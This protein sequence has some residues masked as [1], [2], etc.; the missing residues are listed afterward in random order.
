LEASL[1]STN[2][3]LSDVEYWDSVAKKLL[4]DRGRFRDNWRKRRNELSRILNRY[5][6]EN[7]IILEIGTGMGVIGAMLLLCFA[8]HSY[9]G[10]EMSSVFRDQ[11][12]QRFG[13][14]VK[15]GRITEIPYEDKKFTAVIAFD[16]LEH[17]KPEQRQKAYEEI[18]RVTKEKA[19]IFINNPISTGW[20]DPKF[21]Y[22]FKQRDI[23][24]LCDTIGGRIDYLER[25]HVHPYGV[26]S[27][28]GTYEFI[29]IIKGSPLFH[30]G[31]ASNTV[32]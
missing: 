9:Y 7:E 4:A 28:I 21:E 12:T 24:D 1:N 31:T 20:H 11:A 30:E 2:S 25:Y 8:T 19:L 26:D 22:P 29:G 15:D 17:V 18:N 16:V 32:Q 5:E 10:L 27:K 23:L 13:L 6:L 3:L 14:K